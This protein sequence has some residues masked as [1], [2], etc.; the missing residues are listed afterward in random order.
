MIFD[1]VTM[2]IPCYDRSVVQPLQWVPVWSDSL[3]KV[4]YG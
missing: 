1:D 3:E 2:M 4:V